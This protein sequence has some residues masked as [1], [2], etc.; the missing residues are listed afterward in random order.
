MSQLMPIFMT[1][2]LIRKFILKQSFLVPIKNQ[3]KTKNNMN[4]GNEFRKFAM[5]EKGVSGL[6]LDYFEKHIFLV[7]ISFI[8]TY[9]MGSKLVRPSID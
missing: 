3:E 1:L 6:N 4:Y 2:V 9:N 8:K 7:N 5:S